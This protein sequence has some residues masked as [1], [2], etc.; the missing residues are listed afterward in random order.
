MD[1]K[2]GVVEVIGERIT[3]LVVLLL[4]L[5]LREKVSIK[6]FNDVFEHV[7]DATQDPN[8]NQTSLCLLHIEI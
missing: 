1:R 6:K 3:V 7:S 5:I 4:T 2:V 8:I